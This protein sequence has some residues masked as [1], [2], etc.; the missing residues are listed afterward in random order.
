[1]SARAKPNRLRVKLA[2]Q[3]SHCAV[4]T[5]DG[6]LVPGVEKID[7]QVAAGELTRVVITVFADCVDM[8]LLEKK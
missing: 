1:M 3:A 5:C 7:V 6:L 2:P 4:E 8:V